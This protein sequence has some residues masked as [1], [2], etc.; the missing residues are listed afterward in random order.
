MAQDPVFL[1]KPR[2]RQRRLRDA[3]R[4]LPLLGVVLWAIP[5][6]WLRGADGPG[7]GRALIYIFAIWVV[8]IGAS[9]ALTRYLR[10]ED[11]ADQEPP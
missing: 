5:I 4:L 1:D 9:A 11:A 2:Y 3:L 6:L 7:N 8:L 10:L